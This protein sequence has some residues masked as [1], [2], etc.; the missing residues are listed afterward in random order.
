MMG[1]LSLIVLVVV[2]LARTHA[3]PRTARRAAG[4]VPMSR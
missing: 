1:V 2:A 4:G 3:F